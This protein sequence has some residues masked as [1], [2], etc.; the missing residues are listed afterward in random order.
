MLKV[1]ICLLVQIQLKL[2][3]K[4]NL[5]ILY[6]YRLC[7]DA[8]ALKLAVL[9]NIVDALKMDKL[10]NKLATVLIVEIKMLSRLYD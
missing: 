10:V 5:I 3:T 4:I 1:K 8:V 2:E 9:S 7:M 6:L